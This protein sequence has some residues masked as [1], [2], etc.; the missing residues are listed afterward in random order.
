MHAYGCDRARRS[1]P[2]SAAGRHNLHRVRASKR[3]RW[4]VAV[5]IAVTAAVVPAA[6]ALTRSH[7]P[8]PNCTSVIV[9]G[10]MGGETHTTCVPPP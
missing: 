8:G 6:V 10:F 4:L 9:P 1:A 7:S 2:T 3:D 5:A